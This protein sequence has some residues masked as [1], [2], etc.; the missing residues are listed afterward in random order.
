VTLSNSDTSATYYLGSVNFPK[1]DA[2]SVGITYTG[3]NANTTHDVVIQID[4]F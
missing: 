1:D 2:L 3:N 4:M